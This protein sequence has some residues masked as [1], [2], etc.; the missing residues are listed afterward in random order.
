MLAT[1]SITLTTTIPVW[2]PPYSIPLAHQTAFREEIENLLSLGIIEPST[3]KYS[4]SPMP[5]S[6]KDDGI[7][8]VID[9]QKLNSITV[10]EPFSMPSIEEILSQLGNASFLSKLDLLKG[11]HQVPM[12]PESR[13]YT[14][15]TC[16]QGKFQYCVMPFGLTNAPGTFQLLMQQV[17]RGLENHCLP[18]CL[19]L[20]NTKLIIIFEFINI[21]FFFLFNSHQRAFFRIIL[22]HVL[23][24][25]E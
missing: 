6:K 20:P 1:H 21:T 23:I 12:S 19:G 5:V 8:I 25:N 2:S 7:R 10:K 3:S 9:Y 13:Q 16:L 4:S 17:L 18:Y 22:S 15:F 14:A 24:L 11:F